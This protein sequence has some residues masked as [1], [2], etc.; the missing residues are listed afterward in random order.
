[1]FLVDCM[2]KKKRGTFCVLLLHF[3]LRQS[4]R[5]RGKI[6]PRVNSSQ[7][8]GGRLSYYKGAINHRHPPP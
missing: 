4:V 8:E 6:L 3:G 5:R 7:R 1:M 2:Q